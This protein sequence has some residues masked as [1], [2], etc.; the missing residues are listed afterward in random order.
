MLRSFN[1]LAWGFNP[2][3]PLDKVDKIEELRKL[4]LEH[5][6]ANTLL[7][8]ESIKRKLISEVRSIA[9]QEKINISQQANQMSYS[10]QA[11]GIRMAP[12][13]ILCFFCKLF[14]SVYQPEYWCPTYL[15]QIP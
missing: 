8:R 1:T 11:G 6:I 12:P 4:K 13:L 7:T 3:I 14:W 9:K 5:K 15:F 2:V 10:K